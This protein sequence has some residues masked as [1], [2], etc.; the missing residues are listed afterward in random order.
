MLSIRYLEFRFYG[1]KRLSLLEKRD[2]SLRESRNLDKLAVS[3]VEE[4]LGR[5]LEAVL[6]K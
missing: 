6:F 1:M 2:S 5:S 3:I 4:Q